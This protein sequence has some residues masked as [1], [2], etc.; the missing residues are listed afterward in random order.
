[1][2]SQNLIVSPNRLT[3]SG[4]R[5]APTAR[6]WGTCSSGSLNRSTPRSCDPATPSS[7][8]APIPGAIRF[9]WPAWLVPKGMVIA[10]EPLTDAAEKLRSLLARFG[11]DTT[12]P[13]A[14]GGALERAGRRDFFVVNNMPEFSGLKSRTYVD[15]VPDQ[16]KVQVDVYDHRFR[17]QSVPDTRWRVIHQARSRGRRVSRASRGGADAWTTY[18]PC[19]VFENGL[20]SSADDYTAER[21]LRLLPAHRLR[22]LRHPRFAGRRDP[23]EPVRPVVLRG[24][25]PCAQ[26]R[27]ASPPLGLGARGTSDAARGH[28]SSNWVRPRRIGPGRTGRRS[29]GATGHVDRVEVSVRISGWAGDQEAGQ[30]ARSVVIVVDGTAVGATPSRQGQKRRGRGDR[31]GGA[32][33]CRF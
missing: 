8:A 27:M 23:V 11:F 15:F 17:L 25:A 32:C 31:T 4:R 5:S 12:R 30:P 21:V 24:H 10:F 33:P 28:R 7:M 22:A 6:T 2:I 1:M 13:V 20:E 19:C 29:S 3:G 18:R 14:G 26:P 16:T 9:H